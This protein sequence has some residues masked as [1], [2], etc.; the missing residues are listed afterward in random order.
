[1]DFEDTPEEAAFR[2]EARAWLAAHA[3]SPEDARKMGRET[4]NEAESLKRA[5]A[6]QAKKA[7]NNWACLHWPKEFGGRGASPIQRVMSPIEI[8]PQTHPPSTTGRCRQRF[9]VKI[10]V[11]SSTVASPEMVM[12]SALITSVTHV[13]LGSR[14]APTTRRRTSRSVKIP[15]RRGPSITKTEPTR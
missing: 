1:M 10:R 8:V 9:S 2:A 3:P 7:D 14:V 13:C 5:K 12:T 11:V 4:T 15:T 6:W